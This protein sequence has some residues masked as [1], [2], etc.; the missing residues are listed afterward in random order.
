LRGTGG[1]RLPFLRDSV[2]RADREFDITR[3]DS[4]KGAW[5]ETMKESFERA[6]TSKP[7]RKI[8]N[9]LVF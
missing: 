4:I 9:A 8:P 3:L 6:D 7:K 1:S 2:S 5:R